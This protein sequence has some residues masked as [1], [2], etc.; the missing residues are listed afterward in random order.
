MPFSRQ[1]Q[2]QKQQQKRQR[3]SFYV[4]R[5]C[6]NCQKKHAKC[7]GG[8]TCERCT[9]RNLECT[10]IDSGKKRG[11][12][13]DGKYLAQ[14]NVSNGSENYFDGTSVLPSIIPNPVQGYASILSLLGYPQQQP[15]NIDVTLYSEF[16]DPEQ[17][18]ILNN[19]ENDFD[20][21]SMLYSMIPNLVQSHASTLS[22]SG[23][24]QQQSDNIEN[25]T[26]YSD[27][28]E[29]KTAYAFQEVD[30]FSYQLCTNTGYI[31]RNNH[32]LIDNTY[33]NNN[34]VYFTPENMH[35]WPVM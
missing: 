34:T 24:P 28:Y 3:R 9:L 13:T 5:A 18:Y 23:Y 22:L 26:L 19:L 32:N 27:F 25:F 2:R 14:V 11:P 4:T 30:P 10:F 21:T 15:D 29:K 35:P 33:N 20:G 12:K 17:V 31:M 8:A 1:Q 7:S 6:T 16:Y